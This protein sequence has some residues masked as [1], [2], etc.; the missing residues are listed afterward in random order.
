MEAFLWGITLPRRRDSPRQG[1]RRVRPDFR[2]RGMVV[3]QGGEFALLHGEVHDVVRPG[4]I[5]AV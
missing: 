1:F 4:A 2:Q 5:A 3:R